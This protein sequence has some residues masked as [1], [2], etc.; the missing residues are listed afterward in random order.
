VSDEPV[1]LKADG[2]GIS[3]DELDNYLPASLADRGI[4]GGQVTLIANQD[5]AVVTITFW[6]PGAVDD[7][8]ADELSRYTDAQLHDGA[9]EGGFAFNF[10][11]RLLIALVDTDVAPLRSIATDQREVLPPPQAAVAARDGDLEGV[12]AALE[13]EPSRIDTP[14]QG[15]S[16]L[17][18]AILAGDP[19]MAELLIKAGA[20][21]NRVSPGGSSPLML[22]ASARGLNDEQAEAVAKLLIERGARLQLRDDGGRTAKMLAEFRSK[23]RLAALLG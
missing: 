8:L 3:E 5:K 23:P 1:S 15:H 22:C 11:E 14:L 13:S 17:H 21:V 18:F 7:A 12:K 2:L 10:N 20:D 9:G 16:A 4:I 6:A 19:V